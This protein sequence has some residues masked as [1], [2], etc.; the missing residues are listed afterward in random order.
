MSNNDVIT[1]ED[2][3][4][5]IQAAIKEAAKRKV[6]FEHFRPDMSIDQREGEATD[7]EWR[8]LVRMLAIQVIERQQI[9]NKM[10][11]KLSTVWHFASQIKT[12][13]DNL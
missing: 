7:F 4:S 2:V 10:S 11:Q 13:I 1:T 9:I 3:D 6:T 12:A 8:C 5:I